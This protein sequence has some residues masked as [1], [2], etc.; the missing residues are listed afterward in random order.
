MPP[1]IKCQNSVY[2]TFIWH[3]KV[4]Y[5]IDFI[6]SKILKI[7]SLEPSEG[8]GRW[9]FSLVAWCSLLFACCSLLSARCSLLSSRCSLL[10]ACCS[11][12]SA[13]CSLLSA[14]CS[15]LF[16]RCSLL[17]ARCSLLFAHC[18]LLFARCSLLFA[19]CSLHFALYF[20]LF[21]QQ[22][23]L[24]DFFGVKVNKRFSISICTKSLICE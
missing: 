18:S 16:A 1:N 7:Q 13:R 21:A 2:T 11:L 6:I 24:K 23:T 5:D 3:D 15:L 8:Q 9:N 20:S 10:S 4:K 17:F 14:R 19:R 12:L 22:D